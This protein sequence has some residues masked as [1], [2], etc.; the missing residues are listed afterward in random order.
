MAEQNGNPGAAEAQP[1][2][3]ASNT[4]T[5]PQDAAAGGQQAVAGGE[6]RQEAAK[7]FSYNEDRSQWI[8]RQRLNESTAKY[9]Q[10]I[11]A[12]EDR[13]AKIEQQQEGVKKAFGVNTPSKK[14]QEVAE[15]KEAIYE[16]LPHLRG[17]ENLTAEQLEQVLSAAESA[18]D[19]TRT[20]WERQ[21]E[22]MISSV[23]DE[24]VGELGVEKLT[25]RQQR[26]IRTA[27]REEAQAA[28]L[29]RED[30][31]RKGERQSTKT[32][33]TDNDFLARHERG[34]K[35]LIAEFTRALLDDWFVPAK[36]S[37]SSA[38]ERRN[39]P[40]PSGGRSRIPVTTK[41][42]DM[43]LSTDEGFKKALAEARAQH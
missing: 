19:T 1:G 24:I 22:T 3:G 41:M 25:P 5:N 4:N 26:Q 17:L 38:L 33:R 10:R 13:L 37:V 16:V 18:N 28:Y 9:E 36:R 11:A 12:Y 32:T 35:R 40:V 42:P 27:Y 39:R 31:V 14:E 6:G 20:H 21:A 34:D 29:E 7:T 30:A 8:P 15:L 23:E 43:D 2:A